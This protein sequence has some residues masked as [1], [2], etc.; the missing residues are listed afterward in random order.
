MTT[1]SMLSVLLDPVVAALA[2]AA[3]VQV[4]TNGITHGRYS[5]PLGATI[6]M[7]RLLTRRVV[8][9]SDVVVAVPAGSI[10]QRVARIGETPSQMKSLV[11]M[12]S[13]ERMIAS[14]TRCLAG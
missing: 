7:F 11:M 8:R 12:V 9:D 6:F 14:V 10:Q 13:V 4:P 2:I 3:C 1:C 5:V